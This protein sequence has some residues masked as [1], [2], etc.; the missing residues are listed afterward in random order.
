M[1]IARKGRASMNTGHVRRVL[2]AVIAGVVCAFVMAIAAPSVSAASGST[3]VTATTTL[4]ADQQGP[5]SIVADGVTLDCAGHQLTGPGF[6]GIDLS[7]R[8]G[9]TVKN[10]RVSGFQFGLFLES[11]SLNT[12]ANN[13]AEANGEGIFLHGSASNR[14]S[15]NTA[16]GNVGGIHL[17]GSSENTIADN[18]AVGNSGHGVTL[19]AASSG[20]SISRNTAQGNADIGLVAVNSDGNTFSGNVAQGNGRGL[21]GVGSSNTYVANAATDSRFDGFQFSSGASNNTLTK[22]VATNNHFQ[23]FAFYGAGPGNT[24][25]N[26]EATGNGTGFQV[27]DSPAS[28]FEGNAARENRFNGFLIA[29][30]SG[31]RFLGNRA[32]ASGFGFFVTAAAGNV[33]SNNVADANRE[34]IHLNRS[35]ANVLSN[36]TVTASTGHG[37]LLDGGSSRN[38]FA[39]NTAQGNAGI[40]FVAVNSDGNT[41]SSNKAQGNDVG[42]AGVGSSNEYL[43]NTATDSRFDGFQL[44][45]GASNNTLTVNTADN[46]HFQ[47]FALYGAGSGNTLSKNMATGNGM[48]FMVTDSRSNLFQDNLAKKNGT[49]GFLIQS[50]SENTYSGNHADGNIDG[51]LLINASANVLVENHATQQT[52][53]GFHVIAGSSGNRIER[54]FAQSNQLDARDENPARVNEWINNKFGTAI[55]P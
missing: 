50:A 48:G 53:I 40:G 42:F 45:S 22:N 28:V 12:L 54:N 44:Y 6:A 32:E 55:L 19:E 30:A 23:G 26:N 38:S 24:L 52:S 51:F 31:S 11:A 18:T 1:R 15:G 21:V 10:C 4:A 7:G 13:F 5:I 47:G 34:G 36:N 29:S 46:N 17:V 8:T 37:V 33:F 35:S 20:N 25:T 41:F 3:T 43:K 14:I 2:S 16:A 39:G 9:V 27:T 49:N